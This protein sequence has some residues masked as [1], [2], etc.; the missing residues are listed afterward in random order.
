LARYVRERRQ[1][2]AMVARVRAE[3]LKQDLEQFM[4]QSPSEQPTNFE[5]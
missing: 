1:E 2:A 3:L 5:Q 4:E